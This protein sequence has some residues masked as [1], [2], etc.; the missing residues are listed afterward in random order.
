TVTLAAPLPV[1]SGYT[2]CFVADGK[3]TL[4]ADYD[5]AVVDVSPTTSPYGGKWGNCAPFSVAAPPQLSPQQPEVEPE[6]TCR[7]GTSLKGGACLPD[8]ECQAPAKPNSTGTACICPDQTIGQG[9]DCVAPESKPIACNP[10]AV[11][12]R[13]GTAC[14]CPEGT[15]AKGERCV[16][17]EAKPLAC[18]P[19][20]VPNRK[21]TA[22]VCPKGTLA[23]GG[24]CVTPEIPKEII[25][26]PKLELPGGLF[27]PK[28]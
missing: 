8:R 13:K 16:T 12:N 10:P 28:K 26:V 5:A 1:G 11:P 18:K 6:I 23:V 14:L 21:G 15:V 22:C 17:P 25:E 20:A 24:R 2:N 3:P 27:A 7:A 9:K 4:P 19:P